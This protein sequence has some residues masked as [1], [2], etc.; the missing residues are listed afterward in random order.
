MRDRFNACWVP[1]NAAYSPCF[2][3]IF[4]HL[5]NADL[6]IASQYDSGDGIHLDD[7]GHRVMFQDA[8][9]IIQ[10]YVCAVAQ[11]R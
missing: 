8:L 10:P 5:A 1:T 4:A 2:V 11:C 6:D 3:D 7:A 9:E